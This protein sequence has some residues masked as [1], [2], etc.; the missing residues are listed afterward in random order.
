MTES[1][2]GV[3]MA[4]PNS[5]SGFGATTYY[6]YPNAVTSFTPTGTASYTGGSVGLYGE[7]GFAPVL[8][9][10][11]MTAAANFNTDTISFSTTGTKAFN[12]STGADLGSYANLDINASNLTDP[13]GDN[14]FIGSISDPSGLTGSAE[15]ALF[16]S[17]AQEATGIGSLT[18]NNAA[19]T[20]VHLIAF[21]SN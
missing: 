6:G 21:G 7:V 18:N 2:F 19:P 20:K 14:I 11:N 5:T 12:A 13:D 8:T 10:A 15:I 9:T 16:G 3:Y 1:G 4:T 17:S